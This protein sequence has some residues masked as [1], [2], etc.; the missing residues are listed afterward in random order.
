MTSLRDDFEAL[1]NCLESFGLLRHGQLDARLHRHRFE[2]LLQHEVGGFHLTLT[3][4]VHAPGILHPI[5]RFAGV[6]AMRHVAASAPALRLGAEVSTNYATW[7]ARIYFVGGSSGGSEG[8][9]SA[10]ALRLDAR[11]GSWEELPPLPTP[12]NVL[13]AASIRGRVYTVGGTDGEKASAATECFDSDLN[14]WIRCNDMPTPRGG[15]AAATATEY[16][17]AV[18]GS[19]GRR[20]LTIVEMYDAMTDA[21]KRAPCLLTPRRGVSIAVW[22]RFIY[23]IGGSDGNEV[24]DSVECFDSQRRRSWRP[25]PPMLGRRRAASAAAVRGR[26]CVVGGTDGL[27][28]GHPC[29]PSAE[30]F[31]LERC[32]WEALQPMPSARCG[33]AAVA[34]DGLIFA[35]GGSDGESA[36]DKVEVLDPILGHWEERAPMPAQRS[37]F[38]MAVTQT[39]E[40]LGLTT[41]PAGMYEMRSAV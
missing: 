17:Y 7:P 27:G 3:D 16:L 28:P 24:L 8:P 31:D 35:F 9:P 19:D 14:E 20:A 32:V 2:K 22:G 36:T 33:L 41:G 40:V 37:Y 34:V 4:V 18:G 38:G 1:C 29:I 11:T 30:C 5:L 6:S 26:I 25:L 13:A 15:L 39:A 10:S 12:R 23:A 21:W